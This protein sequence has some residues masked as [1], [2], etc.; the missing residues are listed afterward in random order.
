MKT[1]PGNPDD[2]DRNLVTYSKPF[3]HLESLVKTCLD[4][5]PTERPNI[6]RLTRTFDAVLALRSN[7]RQATQLTSRIIHRLEQY[8]A[9]LD[10]QVYVRTIAL[11]EERRKCGDLLLEMLPR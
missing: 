2:E 7:T 9:E 6:S 5:N 3:T 1:T 8:A 10:E 4:K 11:L